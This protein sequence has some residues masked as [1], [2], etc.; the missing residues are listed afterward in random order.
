MILLRTEALSR[1]FG[2][3]QA[4]KDVDLGLPRRDPRGHR[5]NGAG[6]TTLASMI[7]G[8]IGRLPAASS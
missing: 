6:K 8:R 1:S 4:V 5:P 2:G 7:S 3:V